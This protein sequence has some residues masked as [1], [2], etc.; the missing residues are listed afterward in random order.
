MA[1]RKLSIGCVLIVGGALTNCGGV[2]ET[3]GDDSGSDAGSGS[4]GIPPNYGGGFTGTIV[5]GASYGG[6]FTGVGGCC[7]GVGVAGASP[8][9]DDG[10]GASGDGAGGASGDGAGGASGDGAGGAS[11]DGNSAG[12]GAVG[13]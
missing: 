8:I 7:V 12:D 2:V 9:D 4:V 11:G 10:G 6:G 3:R 5:G 1:N 13:T